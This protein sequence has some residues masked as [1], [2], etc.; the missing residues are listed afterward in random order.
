MRIGLPAPHGGANAYPMTASA[1]ALCLALAAATFFVSSRPAQA[2]SE[3]KQEDL[4]A[5]QS[6]ASDPSD[7]AI[8]K[9]QLPPVD[10]VPIPDSTTTS[11]GTEDTDEPESP[12]E[13]AA[14]DE[15]PQIDPNAPL[16]DVFHDLTL[17]PEPVRLKHQA[18]I[19]ACKSGDI[20]KL[21]PLLDAGE[22]G[23]QLSFGGVEGD[24]IA[25]LKEVSGDD[26]G[27]EILAILEEVMS[28]GYVHMDADT[29]NDMY[30]WPYFVAIPLAR[31]TA[32]QRVELFK[33]VTAGDYEEMKNYG[34]YIF[35]RAGITPDGKWSFFVAGD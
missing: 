31:L 4:Q 16:P 1:M 15:S 22:S 9:E 27:Q 8:E 7:D 19:D 6:P 24:P 23:T 17:L 10:Q 26:E 29:P 2:L 35:Y 33:I 13:E 3:I 5:P 34:A 32:P 28:A 11:P 25:F 21:R 14:P 30:V 12:D 18:I 20:E